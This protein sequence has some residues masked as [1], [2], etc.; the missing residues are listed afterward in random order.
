MSPRGP[1]WL[2]PSRSGPA[3]PKENVPTWNCLP[4]F[5]NVPIWYQRIHLLAL[6]RYHRL[7]EVL[8]YIHVM[9]LKD[10]IRANAGEIETPV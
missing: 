8:T 1:P 2:P 7:P 5:D 3:W 4:V 10:L 6:R 9:I